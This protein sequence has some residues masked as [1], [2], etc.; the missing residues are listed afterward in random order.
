MPKS[1]TANVRSVKEELLLR[2]Q[3]EGEQRGHRLWSNRSNAA[4]FKI[5]YQTAHRLLKELQTEGW[6]ERKRASGTYLQPT[7]ER[8]SGAQFI[9]N[10][11]A[12]R[13]G[14][15]GASLLFRLQHALE[16]LRIPYA[17]T[18]DEPDMPILPKHF[19]ILWEAPHVIKLLGKWK[20]YAL[21]LNQR[22]SPGLAATHVDSIGVDDL[23]GGAIAG[24][25]VQ[26]RLRI[27]RG[28]STEKILV[29][30]GPQN[31]S[32]NI[33]RVSGFLSIWPSAKIIRADGWSYADAFKHRE[34]IQKASASAIFCVNDR[35][36]EAVLDIFSERRENRPVIIGFD[37]APV[38]EARHLTTIAIPWAELTRAVCALTQARI[39]GD[40]SASR[41]QLLVPRPVMRS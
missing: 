1:R 31:D 4:H 30:A 6:L 37:N 10:R 8:L 28:I 24:E 5:S 19:P 22:P 36:A 32:R 27:R 34:E 2:I 3:S 16:G 23:C 25:L 9:F 18:W 21:I 41:L 14:S 7:L 15:F 38:A 29:V 39:A 11:R 12:R 35:L 40:R 13:P 33:L 17:T 20:H 26:Q